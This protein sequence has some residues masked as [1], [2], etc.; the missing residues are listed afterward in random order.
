MADQWHILGAGAIGSLF[1]SSFAR[2]GVPITLLRRNENRKAQVRDIRI[3]KNGLTHSFSFPT[4]CNNE[5]IPIY[6][7]LIATK[8]YDVRSALSEVVHRLKS[9][10][11]I[12]VLVNG[13]GYME[14]MSADYPQLNFYP[15]TTTEGAYRLEDN[16]FCH[17]GEGLTRFGRAGQ[18]R[19]PPCF[20]KW[21]KLDL[22][23]TW[24]PN[25]DEFLWQKLA[26]N[27]AINPLTALYR[28]MNG[29]LAT[30]PDLTHQVSLLC[31]E[32]SRVSTAAG[33]TNTAANIHRWT[34]DI[35][36]GTAN[37]RSSMLQDILAGRQTENHYISG[38]LLKVAHRFKVVTPANTAIYEKICAIDRRKK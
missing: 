25:I 3:D 32:I 37:N 29:E 5:A 20:D 13:M 21:S 33:F 8:A 28:C 4:S 27:C 24:E 10:S 1:A 6:N 34:A 12:F 26:V 16:H 38:Y 11:N 30:T 14:E 23:T 15:G 7:L 36:A 31:G 9:N 18:T 2:A 17:A 22:P 19:Q 35:I